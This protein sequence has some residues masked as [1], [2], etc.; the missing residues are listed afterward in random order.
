MKNFRVESVILKKSDGFQQLFKELGTINP[1]FKRTD[2]C[3]KR[4]NLPAFNFFA[5][6]RSLKQ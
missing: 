6:K 2:L 1:R 5:S 3:V 4:S